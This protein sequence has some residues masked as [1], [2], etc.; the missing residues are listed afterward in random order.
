MMSNE[1]FERRYQ[2]LMDSAES[3]WRLILALQAEVAKLAEVLRSA[4]LYCPAVTIT[5]TY[6]PDEPLD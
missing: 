5:A 3:Q 2:L 1:E 6:R 4:G